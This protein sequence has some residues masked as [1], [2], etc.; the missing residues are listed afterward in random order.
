MSDGVSNDGNDGSKGLYTYKWDE[1]G[2]KT[3]VAIE[4]TPREK[5]LRRHSEMCDQARAIMEKKNEDYGADADPFRNFRSFGAF[6]I[7]V[8]LSDKLARMRGYIER[9]DF[10]VKDETF[11]DTGID[12]LNYVILL[13]AILEFGGECNGGKTSI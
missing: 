11:E 10:S 12:A 2:E 1:T 5:L 6:G 4:E 13:L 8:R 3:M 9:G 7:L